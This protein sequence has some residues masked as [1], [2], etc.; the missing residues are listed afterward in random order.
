M[1]DRRARATVCAAA[2]AIA[3]GATML[4]VTPSQGTASPTDPRQALFEKRM[5]LII[6][7]SEMDAHLRDAE[8]HPEKYAGMS[9]GVDTGEESLP[10]HAQ[11]ALDEA[12]RKSA[13]R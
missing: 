10:G 5:D 13:K 4:G 1:Q 9:I 8:L 6:H 3:T 12:A 7:I 2:I 11:S